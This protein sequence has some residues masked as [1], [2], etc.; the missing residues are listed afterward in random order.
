MK[1]WTTIILTLALSACSG[2][3]DTSTDTDCSAENPCPVGQACEAGECAEV[4]PGT[5][6]DDT[7]DPSDDSTT[8][9]TGPTTDATW[10]ADTS[11]YTSSYMN[12]VTS[13]ELSGEDENNQFGDLLRFLAGQAD[14][15]IEGYFADYIANGEMVTLIDH[16]GISVT[17]EPQAFLLGHL[18][19]SWAPDM[20]W[21]NMQDGSGS[22]MLSA[23]NYAE[24][25]NAPSGAYESATLIDGTLT[26]T[27]GNLFLDIPEGNILSTIDVHE[28][29]LTANS[30]SL[31]NDN[32]SYA[33]TL[34]GWVSIA[35]FYESLNRAFENLCGCAGIGE[36]EN[37]WS[38][39]APG[40][41]ECDP[42]SYET[43]ACVGTDNAD[44]CI[45]ALPLCSTLTYV[46][47]GDLDKD[48][49]IPEEDAM[50][51]ILNIETSPV[52]LTTA[53][54]T[55]EEESTESEDSDS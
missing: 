45:Q 38:Q 9:P 7:T 6:P 51:V 47:R 55:P 53:P 37:V 54:E 13:L 4:E 20:T 44:L 29:V 2:E 11:T 48:P 34:S 36:L 15:A 21:D 14:V 50:S 19:G 28:T 32:V 46:I 24:G 1:T 43:D 17:T 40:I 10:P 25:S 41:Y 33:A 12:L 22:V 26:G 42:Q 3:S 16:Q 23:D 49:D 39:T 31:S 8:E 52:S 18:S 5:E 30:I 35:E 27:G